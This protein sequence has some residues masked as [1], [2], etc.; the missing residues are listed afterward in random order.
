MLMILSGKPINAERAREFGIVQAVYPDD[1]FDEEA[2]ELV[3]T[4]A[5]HPVPSL[6]LAKRV[7]T[8]SDKIDHQTGLEMEVLLVNLLE[9]T[10]TRREQLEEFLEE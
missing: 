9:L 2:I 1:T 6:I 3:E 5:S 8:L 10:P 7:V 4:I